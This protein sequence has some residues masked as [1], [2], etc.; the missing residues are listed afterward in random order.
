MQ[1]HENLE[2]FSVLHTHT[3]NTH[4]HNTHTHTHTH[5]T[6]THMYRVVSVPL[7]PFVQKANH[8]LNVCER[9]SNLEIKVE[10]MQD[11][12]LDLQDV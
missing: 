9:M 11:E 8:F 2:N 4:T 6:H 5:F 10:H 7:A 3:Q 12:A 1:S